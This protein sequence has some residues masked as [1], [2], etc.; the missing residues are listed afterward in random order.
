MVDPP[1]CARVCGPLRCNLERFPFWAA[2][3]RAAVGVLL[4]DSE[5]RKGSA[6]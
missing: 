4:S 2:V 3:D 1:D 5:Y 6:T